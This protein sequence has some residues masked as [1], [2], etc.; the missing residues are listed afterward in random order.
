MTT[1]ASSITLQIPAHEIL[2]SST[3]N[4]RPRHAIICTW[5]VVLKAS[6]QLLSQLTQCLNKGTTQV[7]PNIP[8]ALHQCQLRALQGPLFMLYT[9][10]A[11]K[12]THCKKRMG[13]APAPVGSRYC[14]TPAS[15]M[16]PLLPSASAACSLDN[17][18]RCHVPQETLPAELKKMLYATR[19]IM[20]FC[21]LNIQGS[22]ACQEAAKKTTETAT[23][24][25]Y[26]LSRCRLVHHA[27]TKAC[28]W[29][30]TTAAAHWPFMSCPTHTPPLRSRQREHVVTSRRH[31]HSA[32]YAVATP[33]ATPSGHV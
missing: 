25:R 10:V 26:L 8:Q 29:T 1:D 18:K 17:S 32:L 21:C 3:C 20:K 14:F 12:G 4:S 2:K 15:S 7:D 33:G 19:H 13:Y 27:L 23:P 22:S 31:V 5:H 9:S 28:L 6:L 30:K 16:P 11:T 24:Q